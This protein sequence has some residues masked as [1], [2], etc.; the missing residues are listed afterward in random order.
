MKLRPIPGVHRYAVAVREASNLWLTLWVQR[1]RRGEFFVMIPRGDSSWDPHTSYHLDGT[2]HMKS[3][4]NKVLSKKC[5]PLTGEFRGTE[6]LGAYG[7]HGPKSVGAVC[8]PACFSGVVEV[9]P[10]VLG[11]RDGTVLVDLVE[12][13]CEPISW[14]GHI[15]QQQVFRDALPCVTIRIIS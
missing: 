12:S 2:L 9:A 3:F 10:G 5:Q 8:D 11:S 6:H 1:S 13:G 15:V 14:P 4:G 7:G